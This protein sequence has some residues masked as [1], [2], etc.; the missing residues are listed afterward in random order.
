M[1]YLCTRWFLTHRLRSR[2][3]SLFLSVTL[4]KLEA[5]CV[6]FFFFFSFLYFTRGGIKDGDILVKLNGKPLLTTADLQ[7][8]LQEETALLLEV[9]RGNDDLLF[10]IEPD[11][12]M[13]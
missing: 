13:Q 2:P 8:A 7:R 9:R 12:I 1:G 4:I 11:V 5:S 3:Q 10:N 6:Q